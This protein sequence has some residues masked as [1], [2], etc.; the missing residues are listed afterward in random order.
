MIVRIIATRIKFTTSPKDEMT[1]KVYSNDGSGLKPLVALKINE[2]IEDRKWKWTK[3]ESIMN[4]SK[5]A[6]K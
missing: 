1:T 5:I 6:I 2:S 3:T 4:A